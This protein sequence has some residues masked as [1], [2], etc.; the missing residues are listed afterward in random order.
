[1][2]V[3]FHIPK[4]SPPTLSGDFSKSFK[5]FTEACLNKDPAF[6]RHTHTFPAVVASAAAAMQTDVMQ[7]NLDFVTF[8]YILTSSN[9]L[10]N[11]FN[12]SVCLYFPYVRVSVCVALL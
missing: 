10:A 11:M 3:L 7:Q 9:I 12:S 8:A 2:K 5:E 1:M 4:S 6:V